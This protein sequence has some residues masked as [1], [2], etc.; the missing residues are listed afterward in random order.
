MKRKFKSVLILLML[1]ALLT[2]TACGGTDSGGESNQSEETITLR[3]ATGL[4]VQHGWWEGFLVPWMDRVEELTEG[5]V[6]FDAFAGGELV[7]AGQEPDALKTGT[8]DIAVLI[9]FYS[10]SIFPASSITFLPVEYTDANIAA[11]ALRSLMESDVALGDSGKSYYQS[12]YEDN[13]FKAFTINAG[14]VYSISTTGHEFDSVEN[15]QGISMRTP[16]LL[17]E[18][19]AKNMGVNSVSMT[20]VEAFDALS[21]GAF[22][23]IY[24]TVADWTGAG[25]Q[26]LLKYTIDDLYLGASNGVFAM[27]QETWDNLPK[28]V[29]EA[30]LQAHDELFEE[31]IAA[32]TSKDEE[33]RAYNTE[34][35]GGKFV[36]FN[37]LPKDVQDHLTKANVQTWYD[38]IDYLEQNGYPGKDIA[39]LWRDIIIEEGGKLP[40]ELMDLENY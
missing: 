26:D 13:G 14:G 40:E 7:K 9:P 23:G 37:D 6:Q 5:K 34:E 39:I 31:G 24:H 30:M 25:F 1:G 3:V 18:L 2:L 15:I 36:S 16:N 32:W 33:A 12:H 28:D 38:Y 8:A 29:Q 21:R 17:F 19:M 20:I 27:N 35:A 4:S 10:E 11:N 22:E